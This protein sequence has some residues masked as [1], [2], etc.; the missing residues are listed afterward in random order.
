MDGSLEMRAGAELQ[1][2]M[3]KMIWFI[4]VGYAPGTLE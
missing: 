1:F 2:V 3:K 4:G